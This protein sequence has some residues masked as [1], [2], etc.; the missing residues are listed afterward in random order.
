[1]R[2]HAAIGEQARPFYNVAAMGR[3]EA[4]WHDQ[5]LRSLNA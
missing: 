5:T 1:M 2:S 3:R 4:P